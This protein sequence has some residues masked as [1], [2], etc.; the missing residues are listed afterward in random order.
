MCAQRRL[1]SACV[2][3]QSNQSLHCSHEETLHPSLSKIH[4]VKIQIRL[5]KCAVWS[6]SSLG[7]LV[8][9]H[10]FSHWDSNVYINIAQTFCLSLRSGPWEKHSALR[11]L[12]KVFGKQAWPNSVDI[13][14]IWSGSTLSDIKPELLHT[15][16]SGQILLF[17]YDVRIFQENTVWHIEQDRIDYIL[18]CPMTYACV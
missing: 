11:Y 12:F 9:W 8:W 17:S 2:S 1:K 18:F 14:A 15:A 16:P 4:P 3:V 10:A 6:E 5:R 7:I 13:G